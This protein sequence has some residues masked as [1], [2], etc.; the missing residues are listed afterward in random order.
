[1]HFRS[2]FSAL[3]YLMAG[4]TKLSTR[5]SLF[6]L[7]IF[8]L[9]TAALQAQFYGIR[10]YNVENGLPSPEVYGTLQDS[11]GYMWFA[12]DMG[13][14]RY[15]GYEFKNLSTEN[16]LPDNTLFGFCEDSKGRIW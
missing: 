9:L 14:S 6:A 2:S 13:V 7:L 12:T 11:K 8:F 1:M 3:F 5:H 15:N 16:G 10:N 4:T